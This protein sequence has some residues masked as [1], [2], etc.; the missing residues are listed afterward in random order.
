MIWVSQEPT[1]GA[2]GCVR[3]EAGKRAKWGQLGHQKGRGSSWE[4]KKQILTVRDGKR[5]AES[6]W[7]TRSPENALKCAGRGSVPQK[8]WAWVWLRYQLGLLLC[9]SPLK[10]QKAVSQVTV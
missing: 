4:R 5:D 6:E 7:V 10:V 3:G 2:R 1:G 9:C 8:T